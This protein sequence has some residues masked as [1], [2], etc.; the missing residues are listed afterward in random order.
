[1]TL[2]PGPASM[3]DTVSASVHS[4]H[5]VAPHTGKAEPW[6]PPQDKSWERDKRTQHP[7]WWFIRWWG[8]ALVAGWAKAIPCPSRPMTTPRF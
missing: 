4:L 5:L 3:V 1:M 2:F 7:I 6:T 8:G